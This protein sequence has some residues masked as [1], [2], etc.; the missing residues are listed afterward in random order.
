MASWNL[1][2]KYKIRYNIRTITHDVNRYVNTLCCE[3]Y[4]YLISSLVF[5]WFVLILL[6]YSNIVIVLIFCPNGEIGIASSSLA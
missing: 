2:I 3:T 6:A 4:I 1:K 5:H